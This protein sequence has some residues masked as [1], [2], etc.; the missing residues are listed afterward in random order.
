MKIISWNIRGLGE[1]SKRISLKKFLQHHCP[2]MVLFQETKIWTFDRKLIKSMWISKD[3]NWANVESNGWSGGLLV[4]WDESKM[5]VLEVL[6][7]GYS[8]SEV[9]F[10][11]AG[12]PI[13]I[14]R[15]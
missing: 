1:C 15:I 6:K 2:D 9:S 4:L 5:N 7:G 13:L 14:G 10:Q 8:L 3:I 12:F 11:S